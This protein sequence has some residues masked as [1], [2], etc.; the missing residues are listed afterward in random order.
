MVNV[1]AELILQ[2]DLIT[3]NNEDITAGWFINNSVCAVRYTLFQK[4]GLF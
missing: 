4:L 1:K 3:Y 2:L